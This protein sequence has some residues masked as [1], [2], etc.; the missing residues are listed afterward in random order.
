VQDTPHNRTRFFVISTKESDAEGDKCSAVFTA[1]NK[2]GSLFAV[3]RVFA[4]EK[5][6]LTRIE[7]VP[8]TPGKYAIFIDF[9][10]ALSSPAVQKAVSKVSAL[11][12][13][14]KILGCYKEMR[15]EE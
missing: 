14:F 8:D 3:L 15:V 10:G 7:S 13:G 9:E 5:I 4:D 1:G 11:A 2:A 12:E 6:N